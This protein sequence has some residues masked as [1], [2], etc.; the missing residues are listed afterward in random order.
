MSTKSLLLARQD[1]SR[2]RVSFA[3]SSA[4]RAGHRSR[5][6]VPLLAVALVPFAAAKGAETQPEVEIL[7]SSVDLPSNPKQSAHVLVVLRNSTDTDLREVRLSWLAEEGLKISPLAIPEPVVVAAHAEMAWAFE[8]SQSQLDPVAA[9]AGLRIDYK[10]GAVPKVLAKSLAV[11]THEADTTDQFLDAKIAT[12]LETLDTYHTGRIDLLLTNKLGQDV[13]LDIKADAPDFICFDPA[14]NGCESGILGEGATWLRNFVDWLR[15]QYGSRPAGGGV[16]SPS[17]KIKSDVALKGYQTALVPFEVGAKERVEPGKYLV[18]FEITLK[19]NDG[20]AAERSF[21][22]TQVVEVGVLAES[23][24][25]KLLGVP[26]FLLLPGCLL[27]LTVGLV[28]THG[29]S[30]F[31]LGGQADWLKP[32]NAYFWLVSIT[33]SGVMAVGFRMAFGW[34]YFVSYGLTD[35][36]LVWLASIFLGA[37]LYTGLFL[38]A[39]LLPR[40]LE[41]QRTP[42]E[43]DDAAAVLRRLWWLRAGLV[44]ERYTVKGNE[45]GESVFV[46]KRQ[47]DKTAWVSPKIDLSLPTDPKER[48]LAQDIREAVSKVRLRKLAHLVLKGKSIAN[49]KTQPIDGPRLCKLGDELIK[50]DP[51]RDTIVEMS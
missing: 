29:P 34:W 15:Q 38:A 17:E 23:A 6:A 41:R 1:S 5:L 13:K 39:Q 19:S 21:V 27:L 46:I 30:W 22:V 36:V 10:Q 3:A 24:I 25:L 11:K 31:R 12:T 16:S 32:D 51:D 33:V 26:S 43:N 40:W 35:L 45:S 18:T 44:L 9:T 49:L 50:A 47:D 48:K 4:G 28:W 20:Q 2:R 42:T 7:P 37:V 14:Q 8:F